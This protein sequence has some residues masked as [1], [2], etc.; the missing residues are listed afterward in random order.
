[1]SEQYNWEWEH[2]IQ[3]LCYEFNR[4]FHCYIVHGNTAI[5]M[6]KGINELIDSLIKKNELC[7]LFLF[8]C[9]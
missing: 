7:L 8:I 9:I 1:M 6:N 5:E 3:A 4:L 2:C